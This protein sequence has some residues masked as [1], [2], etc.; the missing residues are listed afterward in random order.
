MEFTDLRAGLR[1]ARQKMK[2]AYRK[3][4]EYSRWVIV[5]LSGEFP[6]LK[7]EVEYDPVH[8]SNNP[9]T[10]ED[11]ISPKDWQFGPELQVPSDNYTEIRAI[12]ERK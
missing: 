9:P 5:R 1:W 10:I 4:D 3:D 2:F 8:G 7:G 6:F 12:D 11:I